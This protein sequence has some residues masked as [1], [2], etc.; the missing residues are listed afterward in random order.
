MAQT[1]R[2][3]GSIGVGFTEPVKDIGSRLDVGWNIAAGA[4]INLHRNFGINLDF[5]FND[6]A[7]NRATLD[8]QQVPDGTTRVWGFSLDPIVHFNR[9]DEARTDFYLTGGAGIY[10][11]TV[12]FT[13]PAIATV[14]VFDPFFGVIYP[15]NIGVNEVIASRSNVKGG[16]DI[17]GGVSFRV[18]SGRAKIFAE[19]RYH[20]IYTRDTPTTLLPV[21]FGIRW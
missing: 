19:A 2:F 12:E 11:R 9:S 17:G 5:M 14:A 3:T 15:A 21:T 13:Q 1:P 20:H 16:L 10:H 4:G 7:I 18:G 6:L 8:N